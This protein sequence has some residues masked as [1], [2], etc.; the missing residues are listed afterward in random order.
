MA[1]TTR[2]RRR[3]AAHPP[4][5]VTP[6]TVE[7]VNALADCMPTDTMRSFVLVAAWSGLRFSEVAALEWPDVQLYT[8]VMGVARLH[9]CHGKGDRERYSM[10]L[11]A[12]TCA[13]PDPQDLGLVLPNGSGRR[14]SKQLWHAHWGPA[15]PPELAHF[16]FHDLRKFH[17]TWLLDHGVGDMDVAVQLGHLDGEGRPNPDYVRRIYGFPSTREAL[18][19]IAGL[20]P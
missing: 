10:L 5:R 3:A 9:V 16:W 1:S 7:Q 13:L 19:R 8:G 4:R 11:R 18:D 17:A 14:F 12:G 2:Q 20:E 6:P 15:R